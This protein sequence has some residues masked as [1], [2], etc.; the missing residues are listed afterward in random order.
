[1]SMTPRAY[2][3]FLHIAGRLK[4]NIRHCY[5]EQGREESVAEHSWRT[6][7]MAML[8]L[9]KTPEDLD[10]NKVIQMC[11][12][13]D[14][15]EAI[16]GDIPS[17]WKTAQDTAKEDHALFRLLD[18][19]PEPLRSSW[20]TLFQEMLALQTAEAKLYHAL[21]RLESVLQHNESP[22]STWLDLERT[23]NQTYGMEE[24]MQTIPFVQ[25]VR[26]LAVADTQKKLQTED[27]T[28]RG[29]LK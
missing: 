6:S 13:H 10:L 22:L 11:I 20:H 19:L 8:L 29:C 16:T 25:E 15:G 12:L 18:T 24:A 26:K 3:D 5:T 17:F 4:D 27:T 1:M 7:L 9:G 28:D 14:L 23:L 21:D 2:I